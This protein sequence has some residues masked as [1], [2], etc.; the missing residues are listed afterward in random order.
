MGNSGAIVACPGALRG[1][2]VR[3]WA[4]SGPSLSRGLSKDFL[5]LAQIDQ[6][7]KR[8]HLRPPSTPFAHHLED[9]VLAQH[10]QQMADGLP[11]GPATTRKPEVLALE[12]RP[13]RNVASI[14]A[15]KKMSGTGDQSD[16]ADP[17]SFELQE[18][19]AIFPAP[20]NIESSRR[21]PPPAVPSRRRWHRGRC[22][23]KW[24]VRARP[25]LLPPRSARPRNRRP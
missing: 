1:C 19:P 12:V 21:T 18:G 14:V 9:T 5:P 11:T 10:A 24:R 13:G 22:Y 16:C 2:S 23:P 7:S 6:F 4:K 8:Q 25:G 15:S 17:L 20:Q 3:E